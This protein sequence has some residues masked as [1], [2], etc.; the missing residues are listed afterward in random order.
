MGVPFY[1]EAFHQHNAGLPLLAKIVPAV[2]GDGHDSSFEDRV[3]HGR[4]IHD[5]AART[6]GRRFCRMY[7]ISSARDIAF[8]TRSA[9][10]P[11]FRAISTPQCM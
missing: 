5:Q 3:K 10:T 11:P 6:T 2:G 9:G 8:K 1:A 7:R 4:G